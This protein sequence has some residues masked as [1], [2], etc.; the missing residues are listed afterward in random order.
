M[1]VGE[2]NK[3][4]PRHKSEILFWCRPGRI[5][6]SMY[7]E[8]TY[9]RTKILWNIKPILI[10]FI[11]SG[12]HV[13]VRSSVSLY[14]PYKFWRLYTKRYDCLSLPCPCDFVMFLSKYYPELTRWC[15]NLVP[16]STLA[17][18]CC[19]AQKRNL[20]ICAVEHKKLTIRHMLDVI[21]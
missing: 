11:H 2:L 7:I 17:P 8:L 5:L 12:C 13:T 18:V 3:S 6:I 21:I 19:I 15:Y 16:V 10:N 14:F 9:H 4:L 20:T 1:S